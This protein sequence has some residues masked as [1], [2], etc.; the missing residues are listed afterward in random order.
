MG[1]VSRAFLTA[2]ATLACSLAF[3]AP[4]S[5]ADVRKL[6]EV[7]RTKE[8][9]VDAA[10]QQLAVLPQQLVQHW[11]AD[12]NV[13]QEE[14]AKFVAMMERALALLEG[15]LSWEKME[16]VFLKLYLETYDADDVQAMLNFYQSPA[17]QKMLEKTP[18]L[19]QKM[20]EVMQEMMIP[21]LKDLERE[22]EAAL[23]E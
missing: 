9:T 12:K 6:L 23:K 19:M 7:S 3:A 14:Q 1:L 4:A 8:M 15:N 13:T 11:L 2:C 18:R 22:M 17:G 20:A 5:E 21:A 16:P 10:Q